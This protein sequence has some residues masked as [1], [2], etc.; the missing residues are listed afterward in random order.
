[1][2]KK[3]VGEDGKVYV[4]KKRGGCLKFIGTLILLFVA[5]S[6]VGAFLNPKSSESNDTTKIVQSDNSSDTKIEEEKKED[7]VPME[8]KNALAKAEM[9]VKTMHMSKQGVYDQLTSEYGEKFPEDAAQ[10]AIDNIQADFKE[11]ALKK[12]KNYAE[13]MNMSKD[14]IYDQLTSDYGEKFTS[15][16]AQYAI[17][18]LE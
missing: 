16:E 5:I 11:A 9:Y 7:N 15:E 14:A 4:E 18:N 13:Q 3:F 10:Y 6:V 1:M 17:D 2:A 8:H 12:A